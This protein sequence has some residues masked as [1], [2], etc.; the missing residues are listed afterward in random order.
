MDDKL[1]EYIEEFEAA[2][3]QI[4]EA[5]NFL[6]NVLVSDE[7]ET[8]QGLIFPSVDQLRYAGFHFV[9]SQKLQISGKSDSGNEKFKQQIEK[10]INHCRRSIYDTNDAIIQ[11]LMGECRQFQSDYRNT[12]VSTIVTTYMDDCSN[13]ENVKCELSR[14][15]RYELTN[16][17]LIGWKTGLVEISAR[18][19]RSREELNKVLRADLKKARD[20]VIMLA[21]VIIA[22]VT[23][24]LALFR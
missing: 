13:L 6:K 2:E 23:L 14:A 3:Q 24:S 4:K 18:W 15:S 20:S 1:R 9:Q 19:N 11:F 16:E 12:V 17:Q 21:G 5:E 22:A 10:A 8:I 7:N